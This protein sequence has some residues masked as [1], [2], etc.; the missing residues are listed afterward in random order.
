MSATSAGLP[1]TGA[2]PAEDDAPDRLRSTWYAVQECLRS[3]LDSIRSHP[4]RSFLT[5]LGI[6]IGVASVICVVGLVQGLA[7]SL[8]REFQG[9]GGNTLTLR[10]ETPL[11]EALR[12]RENRLKTTDLEQLRHRIDGIRHITPVVLAGGRYGGEVRNGPHVATGQMFGTTSR[13]Q[14]VQQTYP[15]HGRFLTDSDDAS[16]RRVVVLG[17]QLRR[18]LKLPANPVGRFIQISGEW[19]RVVGS[20]EPRGEMFGMSQDNYLVMP[21]RTA[22]AV[23]GAGVEP[24]L[25]ISFAVDDPAEVDN[26]KAKVR[27]LVRRLHKLQPGQADDFVVESSDALA[28]SF[29]EISTIVTL[30]VAG[31]VGVSLLVGGVGIMN[32]MLVSVTERTREIGIAKALGAPSHFILMQFLIEAVLLA[33]AGGLIGIAVGFL[34]SLGI[35]QLIPNFP[36]PT[37]PWGAV[38]GACAFSALVGITFGILP[39]RNA[40]NLVPV[41][42]LRYE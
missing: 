34:L 37:M 30:V 36:S 11:E 16:R 23:T 41:E 39:A 35:A 4:M 26:I 2:V 27:L 8:S 22:L 3:A 28:K 38:F 20:M 1:A 12:G 14:D 15:R 5:M 42:A 9:L 40:A 31:I 33:L 19:F 25:W 13:Y 10:A 24:D 6:I 17:E 29:N 7:Q 18:D 32:I 21:Y